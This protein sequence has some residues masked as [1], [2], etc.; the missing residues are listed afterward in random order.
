MLAQRGWIDKR[1]LTQ[2]LYATPLA[3]ETCKEVEVVIRE[4]LDPLTDELAESKAGCER[5][6]SYYPDPS[7]YPIWLKR[8]MDALDALE[9]EG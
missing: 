2:I 1:R 6:R 7:D 8:D 4:A 3:Y 5:I 9:G